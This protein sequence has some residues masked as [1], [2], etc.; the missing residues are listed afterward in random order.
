VSAFVHAII[1]RRRCADVVRGP[2]PE[3]ERIK[4]ESKQAAPI[5]L[6]VLERMAKI[7]QEARA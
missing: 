7:K 1:S 3:L 5:P 2:D 6:A 4:R